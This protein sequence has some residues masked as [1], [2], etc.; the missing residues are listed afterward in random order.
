MYRN[1]DDF[2]ATEEMPSTKRIAETIPVA[3]SL[4]KAD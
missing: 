3:F 1:V 4:F 2:N